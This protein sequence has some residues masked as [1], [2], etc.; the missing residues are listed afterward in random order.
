MM[1]M[2][3]ITD[4]IFVTR[5]DKLIGRIARIAQNLHTQ[6]VLT[7]SLSLS[8]ANPMVRIHLTYST[9]RHVA[10]LIHS[11]NNTTVIDRH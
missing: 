3:S 11:R 8:F 6:Y 9:L 1:I 10:R 4:D 7:L 2:L 5:G